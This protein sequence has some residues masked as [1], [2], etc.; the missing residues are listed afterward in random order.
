MFICTFQDK[1][2]SHPGALFLF[3][4]SFIFASILWQVLELVMALQQ[5][6]QRIPL[7][8]IASFLSVACL[9]SIF[10]VGLQPNLKVAQ[11][12]LF[13]AR[14]SLLL[15]I[16]VMLSVIKVFQML[17]LLTVVIEKRMTKTFQVSPSNRPRTLEVKWSR[18]S[19]KKV[20]EPD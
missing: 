15:R 7:L 4:T 13:I 12:V 20:K 19:C 3:F 5:H 8:G 10:L 2:V 18:K 1:K 9:R 16:E 11:Q 17:K 6:A 14:Q